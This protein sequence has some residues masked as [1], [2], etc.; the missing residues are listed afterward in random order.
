MDVPSLFKSVELLLK[1]RAIFHTFF[2]PIA[3]LLVIVLESRSKDVPFIA[4]FVISIIFSTFQFLFNREVAGR[5]KL[6]ET[7]LRRSLDKL[8]LEPLI[9]DP[10]NPVNLRRFFK[11]GNF[12]LKLFFVSTFNTGFL[13]LAIYFLYIANSIFCKLLLLIYCII[14]A[15]NLTYTWYYWDKLDSKPS[16]KK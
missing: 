15:I 5:A 6:P 10:G 14:L 11:S 4:L 3:F 13:V 12:N 9:E 2:A 8:K 7:L 1:H 16:K